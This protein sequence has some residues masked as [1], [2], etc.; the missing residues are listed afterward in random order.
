MNRD[1]YD[2][3]LV[4]SLVNSVERAESKQSFY[5]PAKFAVGV[6]STPSTP[7]TSRYE[8]DNCEHCHASYG[9]KVYCPLI[10]RETAEAISAFNG[11]ASESDKVRAHALGVAL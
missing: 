9:H 3:N 7:A 8:A 4:E 6:A 10:N 11:N 1:Q 5:R 2:G